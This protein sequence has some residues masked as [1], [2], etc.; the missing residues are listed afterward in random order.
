MD[1][2]P[3]DA[4][5]GFRAVHSPRGRCLLPDGTLCAFRL[6]DGILSDTGGSCSNPYRA[7]GRLCDSSRPRR[8]R[9]LQAVREDG[10]AAIFVPAVYGNEE[11]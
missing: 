10:L 8:F 3:N 4:P 1:F 6:A 11:E 5:P 7:D 2:D 9:C